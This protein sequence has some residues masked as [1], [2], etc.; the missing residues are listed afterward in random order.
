MSIFFEILVRIASYGPQ[1]EQ[2]RGENRLS[3]K[4]K[5]VMTL[6]DYSQ[7]PFFRKIVEIERSPSLAAI[8]QLDSN[9]TERAG[10]GVPKPSP[11]L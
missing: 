11:A 7:F 3:Q 4:I 8:L 10:L 2:S 1:I 9:V 6:M 5:S